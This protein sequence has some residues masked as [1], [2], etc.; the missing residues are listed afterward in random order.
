MAV[1]HFKSTPSQLTDEG[2]CFT[3]QVIHYDAALVLLAYGLLTQATCRHSALERGRV[4]GVAATML[5]GRSLVDQTL[6]LAPVS[7]SHLPMGWC[8]VQRWARAQAGV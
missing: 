3:D 8:Y 7:L 4:F 5:R 2:L 6:L 1:K